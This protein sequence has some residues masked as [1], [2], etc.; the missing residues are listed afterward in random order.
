MEGFR[1]TLKPPI[2]YKLRTNQKMV[3]N[4]FFDVLEHY[5]WKWQSTTSGNGRGFE[6]FWERN[7]GGNSSLGCK[8]NIWALKACMIDTFALEKLPDIDLDERFFVLA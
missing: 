2:D 7:N 3:P 5:F 4:T 8:E 6:V 1:A